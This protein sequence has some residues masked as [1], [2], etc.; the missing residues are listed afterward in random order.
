[1]TT[2]D[3]SPP[4][5]DRARNGVARF[6]RSARTTLRRACTWRVALMACVSMI[7][8]AAFGVGLMQT[9]LFAIERVSVTGTSHLTADTVSSQSGVKIGSSVAFVSTEKII[10]RLKRNPWIESAVIR[11]QWPHEIR[12]SVRERTAA[13]IA[14]SQTGWVVIAGDGTMLQSVE[15]VP[16]GLPVV[17]DV[18]THSGVGNKVAD[19]DLDLLRVARALPDSLRPKVTQLQ[20]QDKSMRLGLNNGVVVV[21]GDASLLGNKLMAAAAVL[22]QTD[23]TKIAVLDVQ[24]PTMPI[25]TPRNG[26]ASRTTSASTV[27][28]SAPSSVPSSAPSSAAIPNARSTTTRPPTKNTTTTSLP[29]RSTTP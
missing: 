16:E 1:M 5:F 29:T 3:V 20:R 21:L 6:R 2:F 9:S 8:C 12:I 4:K 25:A 15:K 13:A 17:L 28:L 10:H 7:A 14:K 27:P 26:G 11:R 24:S 19:S 22:S 23:N 18:G